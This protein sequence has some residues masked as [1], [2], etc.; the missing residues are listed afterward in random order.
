[1][2]SLRWVLPWLAVC[3][4]GLT[5]CAGYGSRFER[6]ERDLAGGRPA[7]ALA[8][9]D[10]KAPAGRDRLLW[11][12]ERAMLLRMEGRFEASNREF[13]I[14]K[15]VVEQVSALS[16]REKGTALLFND[17]AT[18]YQGAAYEQVAIHLYEALNYLELGDRDAARVEALQVDVRLRELTQGDPDSI[19]HNDPFARYLSGMIFEDGGEWSDAMIAYR[20]AAQ[21]YR[22]HGKHYS[23]A[24]PAALRGDLLRSAER[25]GL[26]EEAAEYRIALGLEQAP[27][28]CG[29]GG[30]GEVVLLFHNGLVPV[31]VEQSLTVPVLVGHGQ[32]VRIAVPAYHVRPVGA[33]G[34]V[35]EADRRRFAGQVVANLGGMAVADLEAHMGAIVART[36]ARV[37]A[38]YTASYATGKENQWAGLLVNLAGVLTEQADTRS[39]L[40]LPQEIRMIRLRLPPGEYPIELEILGPGGGVV[41]RRTLAPVAVSRGRR[42]YRSIHWVSLHSVMR[43]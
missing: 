28:P 37:A 27:E 36:A 30:S 14:A 26:V 23:L 9:L 31:K 42:V 33:G 1:M 38:K 2:G 17:T 25:L 29:G 43:H 32:L 11:H 13:E 7:A 35:A 41:E 15:Q 16:L 21:A 10:E 22:D 4:T 40:T 18:S 24:V 20:K 3:A 12:L 19:F 8:L 39:W 6:L 34:V 5:G